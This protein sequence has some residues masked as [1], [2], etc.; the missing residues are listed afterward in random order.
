MKNSKLIK[1]V[2]KFSK[3]ELKRLRNFVYSPYFNNDKKVQLLFDFIYEYAPDF[4]H[5]KF[6]ADNAMLIFNSESKCDDATLIK[7]QSRLF[8]VIEMFIHHELTQDFS[9]VDLS[10]MKFYNRENLTTNFKNAHKKAQKE[11][12]NQPF[13]NADYYHRQFLIENEYDLFLTGK[14]ENSTGEMNHQRVADRLDTFYLARK[15]DIL[16]QMHNRQRIVNVNYNMAMLDE[17]L[18]LLQ[19]SDYAKVPVIALWHQALLLLTNTDNSAH[20]YNLKKLLAQHE[21]LMNNLERRMLYTYL[22]NTLRHVS[23]DRNQYYKELFDLYDTQLN[24]N[25]LY[26]D[27][28]LLPNI[29]KNIV[30]VALALNHVEW[31]VNFLD[32]NQYKIAPEY[33]NREDVYSYCLARL[34]FEQNKFDSVLGVL[35]QMVFNDISIKMDV[36]RIY[37]G[38]YYEKKMDISFEG[39]VSS[40]RK[41]LTKN[42]ETVS[43]LHIQANRDFINVINKIYN[44]LK[45][46]QEKLND[47]EQQISVIKIL[48]QKAW[49]LE[50][51]EELR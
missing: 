9:D 2:E 19:T 15:L 6:T 3:S 22:E 50:K 11:Q 17:I 51:L 24:N 41:F 49:L 4:N 5:K 36:R 46:D 43:S 32:K 38:V 39:M 20:Y 33:E 45:K 35:N 25:L 28:F 30:T 44:T 8:K 26:I 31:T 21:N 10:L 27:G 37:L 40:F 23:K 47:I 18:A 7:L 13:R 12:D 1:V 29:F 42:Q 14:F 16:C 34:Y 48:P